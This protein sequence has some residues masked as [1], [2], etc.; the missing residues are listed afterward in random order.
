M[1]KDKG[2]GTISL[3]YPCSINELGITE[4]DRFSFKWQPTK[5]FKKYSPIKTMAEITAGNYGLYESI[6][7][8]AKNI[9]ALVS[10]L[11][12]LSDYKTNKHFKDLVD[13]GKPVHRDDALTLSEK[14]KA[15][16]NAAFAA[17]Q[18]PLMTRWECLELLNKHKRDIQILAKARRIEVRM[19]GGNA[20]GISPAD[21]APYDYKSVVAVQAPQTS[22]A[23]AIKGL[24]PWT[25]KFSYI[26][27]YEGDFHIKQFQ[28]HIK[29]YASS[30]FVDLYATLRSF[31]RMGQ[32]LGMT[33]Q[34]LGKVLINLMRTKEVREANDPMYTTI[35]S[36]SLEEDPVDCIY[37]II[38]LVSRDNQ[39]RQIEDKLRSF[40]RGAN[41]TIDSCINALE[42]LVR[43]YYQHKKPFLDKDRKDAE[44][45]QKI[46][47][48]LPDFV[49]RETAKELQKHKTIN[50]NNGIV[51]TVEDHR[52][53]LLKVEGDR[54]QD[55][56]QRMSEKT[57]HALVNFTRTG[58][59]PVDKSRSPSPAKTSPSRTTSPTRG[60]RSR[61]RSGKKT[62]PKKK[63]SKSRSPSSGGR[64]DSSRVTSQASSRTSSSHSDSSHYSKASKSSQ[65]ENDSSDRRNKKRRAYYGSEKR[66]KKGSKPSK[67]SSNTRRPTTP[68][69]TRMCPI[70]FEA[71]CENYGRE[72]C[73][74]RP[75]LQFNRQSRCHICRRGYHVPRSECFEWIKKKQDLRDQ[76]RK[77]QKN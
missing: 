26:I 32:E 73:Q 62:T 44:V 39:T 10:G 27:Q 42:T 68:G 25:G 4:K 2:G 64:S 5:S 60:S 48:M 58:I 50:N 13:S 19:M 33:R 3:L 11:S 21:F 61:G 29:R 71:K 31:F 38:E 53:F 8:Q 59:P 28:D 77:A 55:G 34:Q 56:G 18:E 67:A 69:G 36:N 23:H 49:S 37:K 16:L 41:T 63:A 52:R 12:Q 14:K 51:N 47:I 35:L 65:D 46:L 7:S 6:D 43:E 15:A 70:C 57:F 40:K 74:L 17:Y 24:D 75:G 30:R 66:S 45:E 54:K 76:Q 72:T 9:E 20:S 1:N 22:G